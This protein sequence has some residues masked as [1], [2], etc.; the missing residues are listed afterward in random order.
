MELKARVI[1]KGKAEGEALVSKEAISFLGGVDPETGKVI[2][3]DH[4]LEGK[5]VQ[6]KILVFPHG[7]GSTVGSYILYKMKKKGV[8]PKAIINQQ[9]EPIIATGAIISK[10][11]CVDKIPIE[12][13]NSGDKVIIDGDRVIIKR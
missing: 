4:S 3:K 2:E 13:I 12:K 11:P 10:I 6:G 8:A 9:C 5:N 7:K 1:K